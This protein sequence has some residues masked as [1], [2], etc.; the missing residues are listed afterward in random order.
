MKEVRKMCK[1]SYKRCCMRHR[2]WKWKVRERASYGASDPWCISNTKVLFYSVFYSQTHTCFSW[3]KWTTVARELE[4]VRFYHATGLQYMG[5]L[6]VCVCVCVD[7][8]GSGDCVTW[9][10][11]LLGWKM[12]CLWWIACLSLSLEGD[13]V[14]SS[15][16]GGYCVKCVILH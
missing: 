2:G 13:P 7:G 5:L 6:Y 8:G 12:T 16:C 10:N 1:K 3:N 4:L 15:W 11:T 9:P 14:A